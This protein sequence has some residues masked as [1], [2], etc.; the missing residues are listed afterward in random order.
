MVITF[1][2]VKILRGYQDNF[3]KLLTN[4]IKIKSDKKELSR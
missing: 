2:A 3:R 4:I 1:R